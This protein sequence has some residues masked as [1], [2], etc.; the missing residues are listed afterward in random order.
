MH[1]FLYVLS[2]Y[3]SIYVHPM[4]FGVSFLE[5]QNSIDYLVLSQESLLCYVPLEKKTI[6]LKRGNENE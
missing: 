2:V 1:V 3:V 5:S 6:R 4:V